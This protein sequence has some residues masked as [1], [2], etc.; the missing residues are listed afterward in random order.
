MRHTSGKLLKEF[1]DE[2]LKSF[3]DSWNYE[4]IKPYFEIFPGNKPPYNAELPVVV[5]INDTIDKE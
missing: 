1:A 2:E 4:G 5:P 3:H